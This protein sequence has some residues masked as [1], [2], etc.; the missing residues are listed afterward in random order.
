MADH[1]EVV[2]TKQEAVAQNVR[3]VFYAI[4]AIAAVFGFAMDLTYVEPIVS[5]VLAV[6]AI[7]SSI[8]SWWYSRRKFVVAAG[9]GDAGA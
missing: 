3:N 6:I 8:I 4:A 5:G 2:Q 1:V 9:S 7:V